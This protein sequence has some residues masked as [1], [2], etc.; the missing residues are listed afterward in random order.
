MSRSRQPNCAPQGSQA[1]KVEKRVPGYTGF[2]A[3]SQH[4]F[5]DTYGRMTGAL[6]SEHQV[7]PGDKNTFLNYEEDRGGHK[8]GITMESSSLDKVTDQSSR[9][10]VPGY[11]GHCPAQREAIGKR[12]GVSTADSLYSKSRGAVW[13][14]GQ[15]G[16]TVAKSMLPTQMGPPRETSRYGTPQH[17]L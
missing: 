15:R 1:A 7:N 8:H 13:Y 4:I 2:Q 12:F 10:H 9:S 3:G 11:A 5:G 17:G 16:E 14:G 6:R